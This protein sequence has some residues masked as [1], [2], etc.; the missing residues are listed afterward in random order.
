MTDN[1]ELT[2]DDI[3]WQGWVQFR[4]AFSLSKEKPN[5]IHQRKEK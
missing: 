2:K 5:R 1:N 4:S 3:V